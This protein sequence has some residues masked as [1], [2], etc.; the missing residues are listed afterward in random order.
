MISS[1]N[2]LKPILRGATF[3]FTEAKTCIIH[4]NRKRLKVLLEPVDKASY[5]IQVRQ[6]E[7]QRQGKNSMHK[8][9]TFD[10]AIMIEDNYLKVLVIKLSFEFINKE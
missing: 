10:L 3:V 4:E 8:Q 2:H 7:L 5:R 9:F 1:S 6:V